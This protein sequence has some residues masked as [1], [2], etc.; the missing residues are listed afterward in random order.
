M[1]WQGKRRSENVKD[2][3]PKIEKHPVLPLNGKDYS[4]HVDGLA[5][6]KDSAVKD[7]E[8]A[9]EVSKKKRIEG[10]SK[11]L[12]DAAGKAAKTYDKDRAEKKKAQ[13]EMAEDKIK[14]K[15]KESENE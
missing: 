11:G 1:K 12:K 14:Q 5:G 8:K 10:F 2:L 13:K 3:R 7:M 9:Q 4:N 15:I 6:L